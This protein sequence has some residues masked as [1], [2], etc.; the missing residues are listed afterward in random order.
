MRQPLHIETSPEL[1]KTIA[2]E[3]NKHRAKNAKSRSILK[4]A[5][6]VDLPGDSLSD[7]VG[8]LSGKEKQEMIK[9]FADLDRVMTKV[10]RSSDQ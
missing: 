10:A 9:A 4:M 5:K 8:Q 7:A 1:A 3:I 2:V 6:L